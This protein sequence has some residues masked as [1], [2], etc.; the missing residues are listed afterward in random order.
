MLPKKL[1]F[2][3][4]AKNDEWQQR[5]KEDWNY[6]TSMTRFY[7]WWINR[8]FNIDFSVET[9]ILPVIP[10]RFFDRMSVGYLTRDH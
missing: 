3:Y 10:G 7:H 1:F 9:D 5:Q 4:V 8:H 2:I 6:V